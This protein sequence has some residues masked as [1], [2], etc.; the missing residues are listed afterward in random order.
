MS[1]TYVVIFTTLA[2]VPPPA[3]TSALMAPKTWRAWA[4][5]SPR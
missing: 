4:V 1:V 3:S 2:S 5:K